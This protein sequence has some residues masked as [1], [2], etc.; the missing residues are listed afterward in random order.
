MTIVYWE[1]KIQGDHIGIYPENTSVQTL[2]R[3]VEDAMHSFWGDVGVLKLFITQTCPCNILQYFT[4]LKMII[5][6]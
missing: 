4:A 2:Q 6:R 5:F 3:M 1:L